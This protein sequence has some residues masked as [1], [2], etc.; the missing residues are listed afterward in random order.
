VGGGDSAVEAVRAL[1][2]RPGTR[3]TLS[4]RRAAFERVKPENR[5]AVEQLAA[6]GRVRLMLASQVKQIVAGKTHLRDAE[7]EHEVDADRVFV[8]IGRELPTKLLEGF[9]VEVRTYRGEAP[10]FV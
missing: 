10:G 9:G 3:I 8:L 6:D 5:Q 4:Y 2:K 7:G 1:A